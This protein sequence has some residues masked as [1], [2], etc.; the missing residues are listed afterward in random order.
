[1][2]NKIQFKIKPLPLH[3]LVNNDGQITD[4]PKNPRRL[5]RQGYELLK[6]KL[7]ELDFTDARPLIAYPLNGRF[8]VFCGNQ[9]LRALR[10]IGEKEVMCAVIPPDTSAQD[11]RRI[12][13]ADNV[14]DGEWNTDDLANEWTEEDCKWSGVDE[15]VWTVVAEQ[16]PQSDNDEEGED[17]EEC[18]GQREDGEQYLIELSFALNVNDYNSIKAKLNE[19]GGNK[20]EALLKLAGL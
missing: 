12:L 20:N 13:L 7:R 19:I 1:M 9:R 18:I 10:E 14:S 15:G 4:V 5:N 3:Q 6:T 16:E 17:D 2:T 11:I 8:V